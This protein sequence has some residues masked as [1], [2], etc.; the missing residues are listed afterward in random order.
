MRLPLSG[1]RSELVARGGSRFRWLLLGLPLATG[2]GL[3]VHILAGID[4]RLAVGALLL[5][6]LAIWVV[7]VTKLPPALR[8]R[9]RRRAAVGAISGIIATLAYD[10]ARYGTVALFDFSFKPFHVFEVFGHLFLG[11]QASAQAAFL[12]GAGYH[13]TNG[14]CFGLAYA[15]AIR[16]PGPVTGMIWGV[17]LELC[18]ATLYPSWL[19]IQQLG[20]FLQVSATGHLVYGAVLGLLARWLLSRLDGVAHP[21]VERVPDIQG[22]EAGPPTRADADGRARKRPS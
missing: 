5:G 2:A 16:R 4:M 1:L 7:L 6:G 11:D 3:V 17:V 21:E 8:L 22:I 15:L 10:S 9:L 12:V 14:T 18:M 13:L 20:E 19:R